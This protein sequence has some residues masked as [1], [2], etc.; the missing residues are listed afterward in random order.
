MH[1]DRYTVFFNPAESRSTISF[2]YIDEIKGKAPTRS[3]SHLYIRRSVMLN[4]RDGKD[5]NS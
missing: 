4:F 5:R 3:H 2:R 1:F